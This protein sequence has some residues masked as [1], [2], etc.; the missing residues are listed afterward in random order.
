MVYQE[1]HVFTINELKCKLQKAGLP[2]SG[3]KNELITRLMT[4]DPKGEWRRVDDDQEQIDALEE[5]E[6]QQ[7]RQE[8]MQQELDL[9][10][11]ERDLMRRELEIA[12]RELEL[13]RVNV[14]REPPRDRDEG[15]PAGASSSRNIKVISEMLPEFTGAQDAFWKW[16]QQLEF[17]KANYNLEEFSMRLIVGQRLKGGALEWFHS[18]PEHLGM[19]LQELLDEMKSVFD[20]RPTK[21]DLR[22]K[23]EARQW[24]AFET[25]GEYYLDKLALANRIA[26]A[27]DELVDYLIDGIPD[28]ALRSQ[29]R[30]QNFSSKTEMLKAFKKVSMRR[31]HREE[32]QKGRTFLQKRETSRLA[33][34]AG[35]KGEQSTR[36]E[37][38]DGSSGPSMVEDIRMCNYCKKQGHTKFHCPVLSTRGKPCY[39]CGELGHMMKDCPGKK[40]HVNNVDTQREVLAASTSDDEY[41]EKIT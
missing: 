9:A 35:N 6:E 31:E 7:R 4:H 23:F 19:N 13:L 3:N 40:S 5:N 30:I 14:H 20:D 16:E 15:A 11:R 24:K 21:L 39:K 32:D 27:E 26:V 33:A 17:L 34:S 12:R 18:K 10:R 29:A 8:F 1:A 2:Q 22:R 28:P 41:F 38:T 37:L 25:F 36:R